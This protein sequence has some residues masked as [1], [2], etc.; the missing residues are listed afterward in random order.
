MKTIQEVIKKE[1]YHGFLKSIDPEMLCS[2]AFGEDK[3]K[4]IFDP[5]RKAK[6]IVCPTCGSSHGRLVFPDKWVC[7]GDCY[8]MTKPL[9]NPGFELN[10]IPSKKEYELPF[11]RETRKPSLKDFGVPSSLVDATFENCFSP[12]KIKLQGW[13]SNPS[14]LMLFVGG[15]GRGKSYAAACCMKEYFGKRNDYSVKYINIPYLSLEWKNCIHNQGSELD[16]LNRFVDNKLIVLDDIGQRDPSP[17][18]M[19]F[20][21][22]LINTRTDKNLGTIITTNFTSN[23]LR[24]RMGDAITSRMCSG[25]VY[26]FEGKD[27]RIPVF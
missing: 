10:E 16:L 3:K 21:Y 6:D 14:G 18:F 25:E 13:S 12:H 9:L 19:D 17:A 1:L 4:T 11:E 22:V 27:L 15:S 2:G 24:E 20:L 23:V 26:K 5:K 8:S 7:A